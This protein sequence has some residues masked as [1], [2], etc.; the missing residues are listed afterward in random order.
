MKKEDLKKGF[1][2]ML[3]SDTI[4][5]RKKLTLKNQKKTQFISIINRYDQSL[6]KSLRMETEFGINMSKYEDP[7]Y[8]MFDDLFLLSFGENVFQLIAFYFYERI[9]DDL[10]QNY[11]IGTEGE[12]VF[13]RNPEDLWNIINKLY[14]ETFN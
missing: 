7:F 3:K 5:R 8:V 10:S 6:E 13:I 1:D 9:N 11:I 14:P 4:V 12:E 2:H